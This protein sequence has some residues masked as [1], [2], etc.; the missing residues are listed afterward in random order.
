MERAHL[1]FT[2]SL[3]SSTG[4]ILGIIRC[5]YV[6]ELPCTK[7][8]LPDVCSSCEKEIKQSSTLT[9]TH[10]FLRQVKLPVLAACTTTKRRSLP[11]LSIE[12]RRGEVRSNETRLKVKSL[13]RK[14]GKM[15]TSLH[16]G[17]I[18]GL[19]HALRLEIS[20]DV[21]NLAFS[22]VCLF[23]CIEVFS[24]SRKVRFVC[25]RPIPARAKSARHL[26][27]GASFRVTARC[28]EVGFLHKCLRSFCR[29]RMPCLLLSA[30]DSAVAER[31]DLRR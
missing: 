3:T 21:R 14:T 25:R 4:Y 29:R 16:H 5:S 2:L 28:E 15:H 17:F 10:T 31:S 7:K 22:S 24:A 9:I 30:A 6:A 12:A 26:E 11:Y 19:Q 8:G 18:V 23:L 1:G 27:I 13:D 20:R